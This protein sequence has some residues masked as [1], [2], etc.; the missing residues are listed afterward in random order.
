MMKKMLSL[1][2]SF[3][4]LFVLYWVIYAVAPDF[5]KGWMQGEDKLVEWITFGGFIGA[6]IVI[7]TAFVRFRNGMNRYEKVYIALTALFFFVCAGEEISWGQRV[8]GFETPEKVR[9]INEQDEFN[10]HNISF[11]NIRPSDLVSWYMKMFGIILPL[12]LVWTMHRRDSRLRL[13]L[14]PPELIPCFC[15]PEIIH[16]IRD[17]TSRITSQLIRPEAAHVVDYQNEEVLEMYWGLCVLL[18]ACFIA[19]AWKRRQHKKPS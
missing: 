14:S 16:L 2:I 7:G 9:E 12:V 18:A 11:E 6:S 10:L 13:Y 8:F 15:F 17:H 5:H 1:Y 19:A 3:V 4:A